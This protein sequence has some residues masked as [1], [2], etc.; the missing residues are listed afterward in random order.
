MKTHYMRKGIAMIELIFA[1]V[2]MGIVLMSAPMLISTAT[3][4]AY[5]ASQQE[6]I[7][8]AA[9]EIGMILTRHWDEQNTD[10][11][12]TAPILQTAGDS[13][14][15]EA[16]F[17]DGNGTGIRAGTPASSKR[18]FLTSLGGRLNATLA[19]SF[20]S[21]GGDRDDIDDFD[22]NVTRLKVYNSEDT[23]TNIGDYIDKNITIRTT[24]SYIDDTPSSGTY[25]GSGT[26]L[27]LNDPFNRGA[28][29]GATSNIKFVTVILTTD[30]LATEL[31]KGI[32]LNAFTCN[33]G[34][35]ELAERSF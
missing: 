35:Y 10:I 21:D 31:E 30:N 22:G 28:G 34:T 18:S 13:D 29:A 11:N 25:A 32:I 33:I 19:G 6:S 20:G 23:Q 16:L 1:I 8:A 24:V 15:N 17:A 9:S 14:L 12:Q 7:A 26:T 5:V 27:T 3:K 2:I 4:S